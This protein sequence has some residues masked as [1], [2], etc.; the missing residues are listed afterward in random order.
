MSFSLIHLLDP[1]HKFF[2]WSVAQVFYLSSAYG[3]I[4]FL[5]LCFYTCILQYSGCLFCDICWDFCW[6]LTVFD[7][8]FYTRYS[9]AYRYWIIKYI[10]LDIFSYCRKYH[11]WNVNVH[12]FVQNVDSF[13]I[14]GFVNIVGIVYIC[15]IVM[16]MMCSKETQ[17]NRDFISNETILQFPEI[18]SNL[19]LLVRFLSCKCIVG[20]R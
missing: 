2:F 1:C 15:F 20:L 14:S 4:S 19:V 11:S 13:F 7:I 16:P 5:I 6:L 18:F 3:G 9:I 17:V 8:A 12:F 10:N